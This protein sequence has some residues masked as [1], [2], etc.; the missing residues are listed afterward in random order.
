MNTLINIVLFILVNIALVVLIVCL[1]ALS[2][3][4]LRFFYDDLTRWESFG[5]GVVSLIMV[6]WL[7]TAQKQVIKW[8]FGDRG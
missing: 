8:S 7:Y 1:G 5:Y 3:A 2:G 4:V 6:D